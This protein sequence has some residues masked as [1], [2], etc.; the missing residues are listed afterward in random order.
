L[1]VSNIS[2]GLL[3]IYFDSV[4]LRSNISFKNQ[5]SLLLYYCI[6]GDSTTIVTSQ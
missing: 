5:K 3:T 2:N 4:A 1:C 6:H